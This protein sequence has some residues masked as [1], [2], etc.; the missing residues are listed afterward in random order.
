MSLSELPPAIRALARA[1]KLRLIQLLADDVAGEDMVELDLA[2]QT[3]PI[4]SPHDAFEGAAALLRV[5]DQDKAG[6]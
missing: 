6:P 2:D 3:V 1:D 4:W 5:L